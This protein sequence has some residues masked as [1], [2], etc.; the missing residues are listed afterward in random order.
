MKKS[1]KEVS[2]LKYILLVILIA[3]ILL[4]LVIVTCELNVPQKDYNALIEFYVPSDIPLDES[5]SRLWEEGGNHSEFAL[6]LRSECLHYSKEKTK[7]SAEIIEYVTNYLINSANVVDEN[8]I[9]YGMNG[10]SLENTGASVVRENT[11]YTIQTALVMLAY[12]EVLELSPQEIAIDYDALKQVLYELVIKYGGNVYVNNRDKCYYAYSNNVEDR[13]LEIVNT[14]CMLAGAIAKVIDIMPDYFTDDELDII[15]IQL[16]SVYDTI[17]AEKISMNGIIQW[18]Y[19]ESNPDS[20]FNDFIHMAFIYEGLCNLSLVIDNVSTDDVFQSFYSFVDKNNKVIMKFPVDLE[21]EYQG[22]ARLRTL[23]AAYWIWHET[24][25]NY[26][27]LAINQSD[28]FMLDEYLEQSP[29]FKG[30]F[31]RNEVFFYM[32]GLSSICYD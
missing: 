4:Q 3:G 19:C 30:G 10:T 28:D 18:N 2:V 14:S 7:R 32:Y 25:E 6:L 22:R 13:E 17:E 8:M 12:V 15:K 11:V 20:T 31:Q 5:L 21:L 16:N 24:D 27:K 1:D 26:V 29:E 23:G 9:G